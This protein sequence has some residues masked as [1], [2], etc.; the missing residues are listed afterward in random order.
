MKNS[1]GCSI[2]KYFYNHDENIEYELY[3]D[4]NGQ[5]VKDMYGCNG[6]RYEYYK[7]GKISKKSVLMVI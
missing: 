2:I 1:N 3:Y 5:L 4:A 6:Y 7:N